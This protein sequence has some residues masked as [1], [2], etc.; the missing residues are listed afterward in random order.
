MSIDKL[1]ALN[2]DTNLTWSLVLLVGPPQRE[3]GRYQAERDPPG[4]R[5]G[6]RTDDHAP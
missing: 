5:F 3:E 1:S 2:G 4:W 6:C